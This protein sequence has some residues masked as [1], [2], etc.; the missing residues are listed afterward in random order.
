MSETARHQKILLKRLTPLYVA[1]FFHGFVFW[2]TIEKLFMKSIGFD[3]AGIGLMIAAYSVVM[4]ATETPSGILADRWSR[5][6]VLMLASICLA[7]SALVGGL[8]HSPSTYVVMA[9]LWGVFFALYSGTYD[10]IVYDTVLEETGSSNLFEK[11]YGR[12]KIADSTALVSS[13]LL[14]GVLASAT[15]LRLTYF[16][17]VPIAVCSLTALALFKEPQLHKS[18]VAS[19]IK[20]HLSLTFGAIHKN[21]SLFAVMG[22][23]VSM[24]VVMYILFEFSQLWYI[25][26][27]A[28]VAAFGP[29]NA[30][31]LSSIGLG[32]V[33]ASK[34]KLSRYQAMQTTLAIGIACTLVLVFSR[35]LLIIVITKVILSTILIAITVIFNRLLHDSLGST[36]RAG[37][38][39]AVSTLSRLFVIPLALIF[40]QLSTEHTVFQAG[41]ILVVV[42]MVGAVFI[43]IVSR[44]DDR[45]GLE[46]QKTV[47]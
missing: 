29:S 10:S 33:A 38:A 30:A 40:G 39:S 23:L 24:S 12:I 42:F 5:K 25:A 27:A 16:V 26:L 4:L 41:W 17:S 8:S 36:I 28:P 9:M 34:L 21:K 7:A 15:S 18:H 37:A 45:T 22:A 32:G 35:N 43:E 19:P 46:S 1:A 44:R 47:G 3:D 20:E 13:S 14:G 6:G 2:Y 31:M 11:M